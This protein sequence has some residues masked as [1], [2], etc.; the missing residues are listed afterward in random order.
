[1]PISDSRLYRLCWTASV[2]FIAVMLPAQAGDASGLKWTVN[3]EAGRLTA[4]RAE[5]KM[6]WRGEALAEIG[7]WDS[8]GKERSK[9]LTPGDGWKI[10]R[11][12]TERGY[13]L[14]CRQNELGFSIA[15]D[16]AAAGDVLTV[17]ARAADMAETGAARLKTLRLLPWFGAAT[18]GDDGH[19]VIA[20]QSGALCHFRDKKPGQHFVSVYQ[21]SCQC[22]MPLFGAVR[23]KSAVAGIITSGQF[24]AR[25]CV[26]T[27]WGP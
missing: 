10:E 5:E 23:D 4:R 7:Y 25:V 20:Q 3:A 22:P 19:L 1:M 6:E 17:G 9:M 15:L 11:K 14:V 8:A 2:L 26:S 24:D 27:C 18:E 12:A 21:S 13:R 16:F